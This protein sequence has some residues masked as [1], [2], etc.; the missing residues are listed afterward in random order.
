MGALIREGVDAN[1]F[2]ETLD[3]ML[4][5]EEEFDVPP[6]SN[7]VDPISDLERPW[8]SPAVATQ[9]RKTVFMRNFV[10]AKGVASNVNSG[11]IVADMG[12][13]KQRPCAMLDIACCITASRAE[14]KRLWWCKVKSG[15]IVSM[16][17]MSPTE[18]LTLQGW[19]ENIARKMT[20]LLEDSAIAHA[21][22]NG[23]TKPVIRLLLET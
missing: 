22:G 4:E 13:S 15:T 6:L 10:H 3:S 20:G 12:A 17:L 21:A 1:R 11:V 8:M 19:D 14:Q 2:L 18:M 16:K 9:G 7:F 23:M 5:A